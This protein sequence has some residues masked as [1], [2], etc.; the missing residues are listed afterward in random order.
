MARM[1]TQTQ[2]VAQKSLD[3]MCLSLVPAGTRTLTPTIGTIHGPRLSA[4]VTSC[5][6]VSRGEIT[7]SKT[8]KSAAREGGRAAVRIHSVDLIPTVRRGNRSSACRVKRLSLSFHFS[9]LRFPPWTSFSCFFLVFVLRILSLFLLCDVGFG[10]VWLGRACF[11]TLDRAVIDG[12]LTSWKIRRRWEVALAVWP[13]DM[14]GGAGSDRWVQGWVTRINFRQTRWEQKP[15]TIE[16]QYRG[17][18]LFF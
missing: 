13:A 1:A 18:L 6:R 4:R 7:T 11:V 8:W 15:V 10:L 3:P 5:E 12:L 16:V 17:K 14:S 2:G 9:P